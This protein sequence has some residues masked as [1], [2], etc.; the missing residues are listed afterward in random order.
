MTNGKYC[1][2]V[3]NI[4]LLSACATTQPGFKID[5]PDKTVVD[6]AIHWQHA[7]DIGLRP[8][9]KAS[10]GDREGLWLLDTGSSHFILNTVIAQQL[11]LQRTGTTK[12]ASAAGAI[13]A[14]N[15]RLPS[16]SI[17]DVS[18]KNLPVLAM[19][20]SKKYPEFGHQLMGIIGSGLLSAAT[21]ELDFPNNRIRFHHTARADIEKPDDAIS[22]RSQIPMIRIKAANGKYS[23]A[24]YDTG[25]VGA[26]VIFP[27]GELNQE[28]PARMN[29]D[30]LGLHVQGEELGQTL[31]ATLFEIDELHIISARARH[32]PVTLLETADAGNKHPLSNWNAS[33]GILLIKQC[34]WYFSFGLV[35]SWCP[36]ELELPG[37]FGLTLIEDNGLL[38]VRQ[39]LPGSP[40][41]TG[42]KPGDILATPARTVH[43][44]WNLNANVNELE[45]ELR[46]P[47]DQVFSRIK[48]IRS[49]FLPVRTAIN[50]D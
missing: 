38:T 6:V 8:L 46:K 5:L 39:V 44:F 45:L 43:D 34:R 41:A 18:I 17:A 28:F 20:L 15:Y 7:G 1:L 47:Q 11:D 16:M 12:L 21:L 35:K 29:S 49:H 31:N 26:L 50:I 22:W 25:N 9:L 10:I 42:I 40:A 14:V 32:V 24:I 2:A 3:F 27:G 33:M 37:G 13:L 19:D 30:S 48:L 36:D 4:L 23:E